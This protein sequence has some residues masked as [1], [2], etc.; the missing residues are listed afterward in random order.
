MIRAS[1]LALIGL[2]LLAAGCGGRALSAAVFYAGGE[3]DEASDLARETA[4]TAALLRTLDTAS[5]RLESALPDA[6]TDEFRRSAFLT[7]LRT[8]D[9]ATA[10]LLSHFWQ[11]SAADPEVYDIWLRT[12]PEIGR[13]AEAEV[14]SWNA[15]VDDPVN[16]DRWIRAWYA[17]MAADAERFPPPVGELIG[18]VNVDEL[19][20]FDGSSSI[21]LRFNVAGETVGIFK[22]HQTVRHQ[23]HRGEI[24]AYRLCELIRCSFDVP[25]SEESFVEEAEF[26]RLVGADRH[27]PLHLRTEH[28]TP[29]WFRDE[30]DRRIVF[31]VIKEWVPEFCRFPIEYTDVWGPLLRHGIT[32]AELE[33]VSVRRALE[34]LRGR[35]RGFYWRIVELADD[36]DASMLARQ[37][38]ELHVFDY[39]INNFD[40]YQP[41]WFGMNTHWQRGGFVSIDNGASFSLLTEFTDRAT[42]RRL[43]RIEVFPR[44][45]IDAIRWMDEEAAFEILFPP[46]PH[47][48][49]ESER[50][51]EFLVRRSELLDYVDGLVTDH[52][53]GAVYLWD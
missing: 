53:E 33:D 4:A 29:I 23:S 13:R 19:E 27:D 38:S 43:R 15:A 6:S 26:R 25:L 1:S 35:E 44:S 30:L 40:R 37:L 10:V 12:L 49:D 8:G 31:G 36:M 21:I 9:V 48:D 28:R 52:G 39:L 47:F 18:G 42:A 20:P 3:L 22:P 17:A 2:A 32:R 11:P 51:D 45:M 46:N 50:F 24:A 7:S 14:L 34:E 41:E 16:R 5:T